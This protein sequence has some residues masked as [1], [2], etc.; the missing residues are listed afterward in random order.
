MNRIRRLFAAF[1]TAAA[2]AGLAGSPAAL[3]D[4][5]PPPPPEP[6]PA[7]APANIPIP[8]PEMPGVIG[9]GSAPTQVSEIPPVDDSGAR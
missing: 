4:P 2:I 8:I 9:P 6:V 1:T 5:E 7:P 3:A